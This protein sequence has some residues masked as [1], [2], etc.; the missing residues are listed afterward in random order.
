M[1]KL[2]KSQLKLLVIKC[3]HLLAAV[4][5]VIFLALHF[6]DNQQEEK[7]RPKTIEGNETYLSAYEKFS[8]ENELHRGSF[9]EKNEVIDA[10]QEDYNRE[11]YLAAEAGASTDLTNT[12]DISKIYEE[13]YEETLPDDVIDETTISRKEKLKPTQSV[14]MKE[15]AY[16][17]KTPLLVIVIDDMGINHH[18]TAEINS[19][20]YPLTAS[21]LTYGSHLKEQ[22]NQSKS[23]GHEIMLHAPMEALGKVE[24]APDVLTTDMSLDEIRT[25]FIVMLNKIEGIKG[26]NNHM[27]S[28]L[29]Q[30]K[31]RMNIIMEVLRDKDL[32]FLDSKTSAQSVAEK[33]AAE[34]GVKHAARNVFLDNN[35]D[36][37]Y[38][39]Q[40]LQ[41]TEN[42]ARKNGYAIAI[43]HPKSQTFAALSEWLPQLQKKGIELVHLS[44]L[45]DSLNN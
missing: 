43:G 25:N 24:N 8:R 5:V 33:T 37:E 19:L 2:S 22:V 7:N 13:L 40:Q 32:F 41:K 9:F 23:S 35:N 17:G 6:T 26:I 21:F 44:R 4:V 28:K 18:R 39:L 15:P 45:I 12:A 29:T 10:T 20:K 3:L 16:S 14:P 11:I 1:L 42:L 34:Y 38:I 30:D 27:G 31:E 36:K